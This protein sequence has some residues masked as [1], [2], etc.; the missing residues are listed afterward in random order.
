MSQSDPEEQEEGAKNERPYYVKEKNKIEY[1]YSIKNFET[2]EVVYEREPHRYLQIEDP[3]LYRGELAYQKSS[4]WKDNVNKVWIVNGKLEKADG[5][6]FGGFFFNRIKDSRMLVGSYP[7][8][9]S[10]ISQLE[11]Q[12]VS[13]VV[14]IQTGTEMAQRGIYW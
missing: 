9:Q 6:F 8:T 3:I 12:G 11:Q 5:N 2:Q 4:V 1:I 13:C 10:D 14:N 7:L